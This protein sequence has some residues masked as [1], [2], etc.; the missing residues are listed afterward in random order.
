[1]KYKTIYTF[2]VSYS[3]RRGEI[4]VTNPEGKLQFTL[5]DAGIPMSILE[6]ANKLKEYVIQHN[7]DVLQDLGLELRLPVF[8]V[9]M[10][11]PGEDLIANLGLSEVD[12]VTPDIVELAASLVIEGVMTNTVTV[13]SLKDRVWDVTNR[14]FGSKTYHDEHYTDYI[15]CL[16]CMQDHVDHVGLQPVKSELVF[17]MVRMDLME[18]ICDHGIVHV[19]A[20]YLPMTM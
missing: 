11:H 18:Y 2:G 8:E 4:Y 1:M 12:K 10:A 13:G 20:V 14:Y 7:S 16:S 6:D 19:Y 17:D 9:F 15:C 3:P 5:E